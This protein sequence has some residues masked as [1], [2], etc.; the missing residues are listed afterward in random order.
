MGNQTDLA[1]Q[2]DQNLAMWMHL[3]PLLAYLA[4]FMVPVPFLSLVVMLV[5]FFSH[6]DKQG[7]VRENGRESL[8]FQL[9]LALIW[10]VFFIV[11]ALFMG[12]FIVD[13]FQSAYAG[14]EPDLFTG[15]SVAFGVFPLIGIVL[16]I[17]LVSVILMVIGTIRAKDGKVYRYPL[18]IG[19]VR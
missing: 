3:G 19:F 14:E 4:N 8:N 17:W 1:P 5:I 11:A 13:M 12:S 18:T 15:L 16:L 6:R 2:Q 10:I 9:T 7:I